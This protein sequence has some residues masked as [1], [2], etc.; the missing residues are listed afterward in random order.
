M[1]QSVFSSPVNAPN[2]IQV[3][4]GYFRQLN[5]SVQPLF[6]DLFLEP[7]DKETVRSRSIGKK[8]NKGLLLVFIHILW[9]R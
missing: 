3:F 1:S 4:K 8:V 7:I 6:F 5:F 2:V 9:E